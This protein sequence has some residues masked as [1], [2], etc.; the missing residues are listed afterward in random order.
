MCTLL[1]YKIVETNACAEFRRIAKKYLLEC[2]RKQLWLYYIDEEGEWHTEKDLYRDNVPNIFSPSLTQESSKLHI[3]AMKYA[4]NG[5]F[6]GLIK[7]KSDDLHCTRSLQYLWK[8][9]ELFYYDLY[10]ANNQNK[11]ELYPIPVIIR[12]IVLNGEFVNMGKD[13]SKWRLMKFSVSYEL[14]QESTKKS[15]KIAVSVLS[16][17]AFA[18][19]I[20]QTYSW[21]RRSGKHAVDLVTLGKF[22]VFMSGNLS[23]VFFIVMFCTC[24]YW[25]SFFKRQDVIYT[26]L[27]TQV[28]EDFLSVYIGIA[29][30]LKA[31]HL[32]HILFVQCSIDIF[33]IDWERPRVR[34][35][36]V[37]AR[38][39]TTSKNVAETSTGADTKKSSGNLLKATPDKINAEMAGV[40]IWRTYYAANEWAEIQSKRKTSLCIQLFGVLFIL[41]VLGFES[42]TLSALKLNVP[43]EDVHKYVPYSTCCRF[44][45]GVLVY[46]SVAILQVVVRKGLYERF[47]ED[48]LQQYVDLC[49]V[50][51][52]SVFIL[53]T[54][55][56]G[57]Y[58]HGRSTHGKADVNM[59]EMHEFLR[60]EEED[61]CGHRGLLPDT[62]QQTFQILLP[63]GVHDQF[64]RLLVPLTSYTQAADRMQGVGGRLAKVDID[65]VANTHYM[66][67]K[68][69]SGFIDHS[70][71]DLDYIVK[72][73]VMLEYLLDIECYEVADR[74][75]F[76]NDDGRSFSSVLFYGNESIL[77]LF[78]VLLF[79]VIDIASSD[80]VLSMILTFVT[81]KAIQGLRRSAGRRN[82]VRKA[83][84]DERFLT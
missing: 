81:A 70:F 82:L 44:A 62:D 36:S 2:P 4:L 14:N 26:V 18:W 22:L 83:L 5:T 72:D 55:R 20:L 10:L 29:F 56:F 69:L 63:P 65:R 3:F 47:V 58:I 23:T 30:A 40:S 11:S 33:Y 53:I 19:S 9:S 31:V 79:S 80:Y 45:L 52:V 39:A 54:K 74:G 17:M 24:L 28:Q 71:K 35:S 41:N 25:F 64:L 48:K 16:T 77:L 13:M 51:N 59:K 73:R 75:Y 46:L 50:S 1:L 8:S 61:L 21:F 78:D 67:N 84:V 60:K 6:L 27:P 38:V 76:Y 15:V 34:A 37:S 66:L 68:F 7:I 42:S 43:P 57:Y 12:N 49:S 32:I